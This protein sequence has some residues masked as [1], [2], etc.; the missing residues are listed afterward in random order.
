MLGG[1]DRRRISVAGHNILQPPAV[2]RADV[3][4]LD[5]AHDMRGAAELPHQV[6]E[7]VFVDAAAHHR[8][9]LDRLEARR[10]APPRCREHLLGRE[11]GVVHAPEDDRV[12]G[13]EADREARQARR[14]QRRGLEPEQRT[15]GG[16][17]DRDA[18]RQR[19]AG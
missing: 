10:L 6:E 7:S 18:E 17:G 9:D 12:E 2:R 15:V 19:A 11:V 1:D 8:V 16:E 13:V 3:H 5:E 14:A 4:V